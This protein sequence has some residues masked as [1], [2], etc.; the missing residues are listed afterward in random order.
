MPFDHHADNKHTVER[1]WT[2]YQVQREAAYRLYGTVR[3]ALTH[4]LVCDVRQFECMTLSEFNTKTSLNMQELEH[5]TAMDMFSAAEACFWRDYRHRGVSSE[6]DPFTVAM[7]NLYAGSGGP[8]FYKLEPVIKVWQA[9][10]AHP[11]PQ[12]FSEFKGALHYRHWLA[13]GRHWD[14]NVKRYTLTQVLDIC[15]RVV[16][17]VGPPVTVPETS[18]LSG[19]W[20][21]IRT[22]FERLWSR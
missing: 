19:V 22:V 4:D 5:L 16:D 11:L 1:C 21:R 3:N 10:T 14:L 20:H 12:Y 13:H 2:W 17:A 6:V 8:S 7:R 18:W 9:H 15:T